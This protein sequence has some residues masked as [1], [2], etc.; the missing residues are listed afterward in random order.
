M[1]HEPDAAAPPSAHRLR[2]ADSPLAPLARSCSYVQPDR[3][4]ARATIEQSTSEGHMGAPAAPFFAWLRQRRHTASPSPTTRTSAAARPLLRASSSGALTR[5][6]PPH[7]AVSRSSFFNMAAQLTENDGDEPFEANPGSFFTPEVGKPASHRLIQRDRPFCQASG[8]FHMERRSHLFNRLARRDWFHVVLSMPTKYSFIIFFA[9]YTIAIIFFA[10]CYIIADHACA[11]DV[12]PDSILDFRKAFA[13]SLETMTTIGY[14]LPSDRHNHDYFEGCWALPIIVH[15]QAMVF[16]MM[17]ALFVGLLFT[18]LARGS[19]RSAMIVF[20]NKAC[21]RCCHGHF[22]FLFQERCRLPPAV[23]E[24]SFFTY[25]PVVEAHVRVYAVLHEQSTEMHALFQ[26]RVMRITNPNDELGGMLFLPTPQVVTHQIDRWSPLFPPSAYGPPSGPRPPLFPG[27][28]GRDSDSPQQVRKAKSVANPASS[29][30]RAPLPVRPFMVP[31]EVL[32]SHGGS[33]P[34]LPVEDQLGGG[35]HEQ[36]GNGELPMS[37]ITGSTETLPHCVDRCG[38]AQLAQHPPT[39]RA[40]HGPDGMQTPRDEIAP[41]CTPTTQT[42]ATSPLLARAS[43]SAELRAE[44]SPA[45]PMIPSEAAQPLLQGLEEAS[46]GNDAPSAAPP[47][48]SSALASLGLKGVSIRGWSALRA[49]CLPT[50]S[51]APGQTEPPPQP[52]K[53]NRSENASGSVR[54]QEML[55]LREKIRSHISTSEVEVIVLVE[56]IDPHSGLNFQESLD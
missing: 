49:R 9:V 16:M 23:G 42:L 10:F 50:S 2:P 44:V 46:D 8:K 25:H 33:A 34:S 22:Y 17:N 52:P 47:S 38:D 39:C 4:H 14:G 15:F 26:T 43:P 11:N 5:G 28:V 27:L 20:T 36:Q 51:E 21:I 32:R 54:I 56:A 29:T 24:C 45:P 31:T 41:A 3:P 19:N 30:P 7:S 6:S 35:L 55:Q 48:C 13:F 1:R 12:D 53:P 18:R 37:R 40:S